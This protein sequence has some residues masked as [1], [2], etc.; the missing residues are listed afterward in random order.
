[1]DFRSLQCI[2]PFTHVFSPG[3]QSVRTSGLVLLEA[4]LFGA[5]LLYFPVSPSSH[6]NDSRRHDNHRL[7]KLPLQLHDT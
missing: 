1:M 4:I 3:F 5:L 2:R 7:I 6:H